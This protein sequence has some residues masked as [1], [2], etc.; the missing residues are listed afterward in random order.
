MA[1][2]LYVAYFTGVAGQSLGLF[3]I[4]DGLLAGID[5]TAMQYDGFYQTNRDGSLEGIVEYVLPAGVSLIT[6]AP[7]GVAPTRVSVKLNLPAG[8]D[9]GRV[10]TIET[11]LGPV[12]AKFEKLKDIP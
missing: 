6:G 12:N 5:A 11:P 8:F 2:A 10:I 7:S 3:Y 1:K 9:D 4:G